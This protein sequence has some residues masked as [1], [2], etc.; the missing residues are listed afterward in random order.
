M[1]MALASKKKF[2]MQTKNEVDLSSMYEPR[3]LMMQT[4]HQES[5]LFV[6]EPI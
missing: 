4:F 6:S 2:G 5:H 3:S 1:C